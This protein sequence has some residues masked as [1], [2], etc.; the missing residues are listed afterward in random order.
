MSSSPFATGTDFIDVP[1]QH[2]MG[3]VSGLLGLLSPAQPDD[4]HRMCV[5]VT[6]GSGLVGKGIE[7][8]VEQ[9]VQR[10]EKEQ[11]VYLS[12]KEADLRDRAATRYVSTLIAI[13][14]SELP[15]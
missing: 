7:A 13:S 3:A 14:D 11:W 12:S 10:G 15:P 8:V 5:L 2:T 4:P 6:G 1:L 9:D